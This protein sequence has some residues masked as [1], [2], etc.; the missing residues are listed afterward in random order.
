MLLALGGA[1]IVAL[2]CETPRQYGLRHGS[3]AVALAI[4][5]AAL[6]SGIA[7][8]A[9]SGICGALQ[10]HIMHGPIQ[11]VRLMMT[12]ASPIRR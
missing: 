10:F 5:V 3:V 4:F 8:F 12:A 7:S 9:F 11:I 2:C 1:G 6:T